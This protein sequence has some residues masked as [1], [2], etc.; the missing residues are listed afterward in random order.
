MCKALWKRILED[1][2]GNL[3]QSTQ[4]GIRKVKTGSFAFIGDQ[5]N[6]GMEIGNDQ[7]LTLLEE[8]FYS[9]NFAMALPKNSPYTKR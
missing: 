8:M 3:V 1:P 6:L 4:D 7:G 2:K 9:A 5:T